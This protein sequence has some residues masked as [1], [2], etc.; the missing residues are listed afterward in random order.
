MATRPDETSDDIFLGKFESNTKY[1]EKL[2]KEVTTK[3]CA[4]LNSNG[5]KITLHIDTLDNQMPDESFPNT[6]LLTRIFEQAMISIIGVC[7]AVEKI[8]VQVSK[9]KES[10]EIQV[11]KAD[12]LVTKNYNL[13]LPSE[14]QVLQVTPKETFKEVVHSIIDRKI[15]TTERVTCNSH[16]KVFNKGN[17][18]GMNESNT[19]QFKCLKATQSKNT[20]LADRMMRKEN[21][22]RWYV[23]A[24]GN[25]NG[26]HV[27]YG[28][29]D[30]GVVEGEL[31]QC[32]EKS[33]ITK[34]V[35]DT[36]SKMF[37][38][39]RTGPP[40]QGEDW[41][42][43]FEQVVDEN[44][45]PIPS[46]FVIVIYI[47]PCLGGVFTDKPECYEMVNENVKKMSFERWMDQGKC[48]SNE[49]VV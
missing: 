8:H 33:K 16:C 18:C 37:C 26:G 21:K 35:A 2:V 42:I 39:K 32:G 24:F 38:P 29:R 7:L 46:T 40:K 30:N 10:I 48:K 45:H 19:Q 4:R 1:K 6:R 47:A 12:R 15:N 17:Y 20:T 5:G 27:Y 43:F 23:S 31:V 36:I 9:D 3:I 11:D 14:S 28:I 22:F 25:H 34:K 13:Y 44:S 41:E 49:V